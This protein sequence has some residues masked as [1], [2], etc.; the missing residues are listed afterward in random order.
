MVRIATNR[1][2]SLGIAAVL[3]G[4]GCVAAPSPQPPSPPATSTPVTSPTPTTTPSAAPASTPK[5]TPVA[6]ASPPPA[7]WLE[8]PP[9]DSVTGVQFEDVVWTGTRFVATG[10]G[11]DEVGA[12]LDSADGIK[13]HRQANAGKGWSPSRLAAGP[14]GVV[15]VGSIGGRA[16]SWFSADGLTWVVRRDAFPMPAVGTD[17][18][19]VTDV[20]ARGDGWLAV[21]HQELV[22]QIDCGLEFI[23]AYVW[24]SN[25]GLHWTR[26][27]N[28]DAL[29]GGGMLAVAHGDVHR[30]PET[31]A[32]HQA[33][34]ILEGADWNQHIVVIA[35]SEG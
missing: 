29:K 17:E 33:V 26:L 30:A 1:W 6:T 4:A 8:V 2:I 31:V 27:P 15:A 5:P 34:D 18:I 28:Q 10:G 24:T 22:C 32:R 20:V 23:R 35:R 19:E 14:G 25:D 7:A 12:F 21:G 3:V 16:T 11:L 9:Q 13:W